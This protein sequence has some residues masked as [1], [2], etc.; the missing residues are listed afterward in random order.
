MAKFT[1][2]V[3]EKVAPVAGRL[4]Q[5][6]H[7]QA[8][9]RTFSALMPLITVGSFALLLSTPAADAALMEQGFLREAA[10]VWNWVSGAIGPAGRLLYAV[11]M[12]PLS[13]YVS[14]GLGYFLSE[15]RERKG[16]LPALVCAAAFLMTVGIGAGNV[17]DVDRL[18]TRGLFAAIVV[19]CL[20]F[21]LWRV[22]SSSKAGRMDLSAAGVP[23]AI[24][25]GLSELMPA[26]LTVCAFAVLSAV[27]RSLFGTPLSELMERLIAPVAGAVDSLVGVAVL[28][29]LVQVLWWFGIHDSVL[30]NPLTP[31]LTANLVANAAAYAEGTSAAL[32]PHIVTNTFWAMFGIGCLSLTLAVLCVSSR[33]K[34][35]REVGR[36]ALVPSIFNISEPLLFGLPVMYNTTLL[37]PFLVI[38]PLNGVLSYL[39]MSHGLINRT[40]VNFGW[41]MPALLGQVISTVDLRGALVYL[42][43]F[44][45]DILIWLP[46]FKVYERRSLAEESEE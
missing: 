5:Q 41:S 40:V 34:R 38:Q 43:M 10:R 3:E 32:L 17:L 24:T 23:G 26:A 7:L 6:T 9:T 20:A 44:V 18:G 37:I 36:I 46:F 22:L 45:M 25:E 13:I 15:E 31:F 8:L 28:L 21:E 39:A 35:I 2:W 33:S 19:S 42:A 30:T 11:T 27:I 29:M 4:T 12:R 1:E 14:F 16:L